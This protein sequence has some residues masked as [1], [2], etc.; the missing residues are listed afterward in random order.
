MKD[1]YQ[2]SLLIKNEMILNGKK[3][4]LKNITMPLLNVMAEFD[5][6]VPTDASKPLSD[7]VSSSDKETLVLCSN[8]LSTIQVVRAIK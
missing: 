5:H 4:N 6:L 1:C 3:I 7:V 2:K 8:V